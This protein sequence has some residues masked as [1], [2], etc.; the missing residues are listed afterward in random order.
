MPKFKQI[1]VISLG[2]SL[3]FPHEIDVDFLKKFKKIIIDYIKK[4]NRVIL[5]TG[6]GKICRKYNE[7]ARKLNNKVTARELDWMG[8]KATKVNAE[9]VRIMFNHNAYYKVL[10][11]PDEKLDKQKNR[12]IIVAGG[13]KPGA[14]SDNMAVNL[15]KYFKA[16][17]VINLTNIDYIY[18]KDPNKYK[19]AKI[20]KEITWSQFRKL[21][22]NKWDPG[23]NWPFDPIAS[24]LAQQLK[25]EV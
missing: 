3:I 10:D 8:I 16:D 22:G 25:L 5:V 15:A 13:W 17:K 9:L 18:D 19:Y 7:A 20:L 6:G 12:Q 23:A 24:K 2:G 14:S 11:R 21:I 4:G 1:I